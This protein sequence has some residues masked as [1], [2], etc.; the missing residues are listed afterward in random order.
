MQRIKVVTD[1]GRGRHYDKGEKLPLVRGAF[2]PGV[3]VAEFACVG[4]V[5]TSFLRRWRRQFLDAAAERPSFAS[6][7]VTDDDEPAN[8]EYLTALFPPSDPELGVMK[9]GLAGGVRLRI[10]G[11][12]D[13]AR[14]C[15]VMEAR[16]RRQ[17]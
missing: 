12:A 5:D 6:P 11:A 14:I 10:T 4:G 17:R 3:K 1:G 2:W 9:V 7:V 15:M 13:P 8:A 16:R